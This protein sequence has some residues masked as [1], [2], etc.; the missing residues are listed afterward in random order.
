VKLTGSGFRQ[1][2]AEL[3][4]WE[5]GGLTAFEVALQKAV[6]D[7]VLLWMRDLLQDAEITLGWDRGE[8]SV[9]V[10]LGTNDSIR[11]GS[12]RL[13]ALLREEL[14]SGMLDR[15]EAEDV[16]AVLATMRKRRQLWR[17]TTHGKEAP[18]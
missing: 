4:T 17:R 18:A 7:I 16:E 10:W 1:L 8:A 5:V 2:R 9:V 14:L 11:L 15:D 3:R 13:T 12:A 6:R